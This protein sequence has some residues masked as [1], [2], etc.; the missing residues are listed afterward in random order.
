MQYK[1]KTQ[2]TIDCN[3]YPEVLVDN[4]LNIYLSFNFMLIFV[5]H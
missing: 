1:K 3:G 4:I 2:L 5:M